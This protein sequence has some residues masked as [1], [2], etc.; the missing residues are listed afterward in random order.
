MPN[1]PASANYGKTKEFAEDMNSQGLKGLRYKTLSHPTK[2]TPSDTFVVFD[3][4]VIEILEKYGIVG[5]VLLSAGLAK[6]GLED[7]DTS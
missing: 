3:D 5:P 2:T 4:K 6:E 1:N 7:G